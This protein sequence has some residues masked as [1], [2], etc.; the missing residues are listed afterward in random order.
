MPLFFILFTFAIGFAAGY[1]A[2]SALVQTSRRRFAP[3]T[4]RRRA[5]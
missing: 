3:A 1:L 2:R 4:F 5:F